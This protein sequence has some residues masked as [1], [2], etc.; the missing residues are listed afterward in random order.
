MSLLLTGGTGTLGRA[1]IARATARGL[2]VRALSRRATG[3][4]ETTG[5]V[6]WIQGDIVSG[7]GLRDA[8]DGVT[9]IV[10][11]A[12][13]SRRALSVDVHGTTRLVA[14][15]REAAVAHFID[16]SI[17][18]IDQIP[19]PYYRAKL[20][21]EGIV[22]RSGIPYSILRATQFHSFID[23]LLSRAARRPLVM[24]LPVRLLVQSVDVIEVADRLLRAVD[25]GPQGR[26]RDFGGPEIMTVGQAAAIWRERRRIRKRVLPLPAVGGV[27]SAIRRGH[28]T[29]PSGEHGTVT[30]RQWL[31]RMT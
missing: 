27:L 11:A 15:A 30:W 22:Q 13:D 28:S 1:L 20:E 5:N 17:V 26:L 31:E 8:L 24:P 12:S 25:E 29:T 18:G 14:A 19:Y 3:Q 9:T 2:R 21:A 4:S 7:E 16:V 10:H 23:L 6:S